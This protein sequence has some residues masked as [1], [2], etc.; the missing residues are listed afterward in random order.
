M[1]GGSTDRSIFPA[2][3]NV[4]ATRGIVDAAFSLAPIIDFMIAAT[5]ELRLLSLLPSTNQAFRNCVAV[6]YY[7][8][9]MTRR[10]DHLETQKTIDGILKVIVE[11]GM[12]T[13][14]V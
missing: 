12:L 4:Y 1:S 10:T 2:V 3:P 9:S 5:C 13:T 6:I 14:G 8:K 11:T 7:L